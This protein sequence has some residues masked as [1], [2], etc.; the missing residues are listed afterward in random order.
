MNLIHDH[1]L[2]LD[3]LHTLV[4]RPAI[5]TRSGHNIWTD[6]HVG[7][8]MLHFHLNPDIDSASLKHSTID[9]QV[10]WITN[11]VGGAG[12]KTLLDIGCGPGLFCERFDS[13]GFHVTGMDFNR[14]SIEHARQG[15]EKRERPIE[16]IHANYVHMNVTDAFDVVTLINRDF[17]ALTDIERD[18]LLTVVHRS[19]HRGGVFVFDVMAGTYYRRLKEAQ[20]FHVVERDGFWASGPHLVLEQTFLYEERYVQ[21]DQYIV[22]RNDGT[23][24]DFH[25]WNT[26]YTEEEA[27]HILDGAGFEI[28]ASN[29]FLSDTPYGDPEMNLGFVARKR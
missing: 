20:R 21:L 25:N 1:N 2:N 14:Y 7:R 24:R 22:I 18:R 9:G 27:G 26:Y 8:Q 15:A 3:L 29:P 28:V 17:G 4:Q 23:V 6:D 19:L 12:E 16:Y 5:Y 13:A 11:Q 10:K